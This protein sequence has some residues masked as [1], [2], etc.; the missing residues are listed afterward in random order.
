MLRLGGRRG[1]AVHT[2]RGLDKHFSDRAQATAARQVSAGAYLS[3]GPSLD[4]TG[5]PRPGSAAEWQRGSID[6]TGLPRPGSA[7]EWQRGS[8]DADY[9]AFLE[10]DRD[11][12][13]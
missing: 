11:E 10:R 3:V 1:L 7:A 12:A 9:A 2:R 8:I 13:S 5:L 6:G 4:G